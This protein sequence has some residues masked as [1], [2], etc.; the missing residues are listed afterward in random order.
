M[1]EVI[2][3][4]IVSTPAPTSLPR[5]RTEL[6][7]KQSLARLRPPLSGAASALATRGLFDASGDM[8]RPASLSVERGTSLFEIS[9]TSGF[10]MAADGHRLENL[11]VCAPTANDAALRRAAAR[12][13]RR[14]YLCPSPRRSRGWTIGTTA[15]PGP[16]PRRRRATRA[17]VRLRRC[18]CPARPYS[19]CCH[20][21]RP[22]RCAVSGSQFLGFASAGLR[23]ARPPDAVPGFGDRLVSRRSGRGRGPRWAARARAALA[24][25]PRQ[26]PYDYYRSSA[27]RVQR[28]AQGP[29]TRAQAHTFWL[30]YG[31]A[32]YWSRPIG[33]ASACS[34]SSTRD[35]RS[36]T[37]RPRAVGSA[38]KLRS[39]PRLAPGVRRASLLPR[40]APRPWRPHARARA[41]VRVCAGQLGSAGSD[42]L[43]RRCRCRHVRHR[44]KWRHSPSSAGAADPFG[45]PALGPRA[46]AFGSARSACWIA[47]LS[48]APDHLPRMTVIRR[49]GIARLSLSH[50]GMLGPV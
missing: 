50:L 5:R 42:G 22:P 44:I 4:R 19:R 16:D 2:P 8:R 40:D 20:T 31:P 35:L 21:W 29:W 48:R 43:E 14:S 46:A 17:A 45:P 9:A 12:L 49:S 24:A 37:R 47:R 11:T 26:V 6:Q 13:Q 41:R 3:D 25:Q 36:I 15:E 28:P 27:R 1:P 32:A 30:K 18:P 33:I 39:I 38:A 23:A 7:I 34:R 10:L